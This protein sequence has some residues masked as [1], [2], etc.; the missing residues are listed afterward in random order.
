[1][2]IKAEFSSDTNFSNFVDAVGWR[3]PSN[4]MEIDDI[5][6][7]V[8]FKGDPPDHLVQDLIRD[9]GGVTDE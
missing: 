8:V 4:Q 5:E 6:L 9:N 3:Y 2:S 1:M 7:T